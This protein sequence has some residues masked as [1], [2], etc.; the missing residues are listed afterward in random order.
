M[1][2]FSEPHEPTSFRYTRSRD[3]IGRNF[4][5]M[6][7]K[8]KCGDTRTR[9]VIRTYRETRTHMVIRTHKDTRTYRD[10]RTHMVKR[11]YRDTRTDTDKWQ[12]KKHNPIRIA[13]C[14]L[15]LVNGIQTN[16]NFSQFKQHRTFFWYTCI[17][18][19]RSIDRLE[20]LPHT[21]LILRN[22]KSWII[23]K[24]P[25]SGNIWTATWL[26]GTKLLQSQTLDCISI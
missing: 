23:K 1:R 25:K 4:V 20:L 16:W 7:Q 11:T 18:I 17:S 24:K 22:I 10:T 13:V 12:L 8:L 26:K 9:T 6:V 14:H 2:V 19:L 5:I 3:I 15:R 21:L